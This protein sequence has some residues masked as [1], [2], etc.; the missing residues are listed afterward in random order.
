MERVGE[1]RVRVGLENDRDLALVAAGRLSHGDARHEEVD[2]LVDTG[3]VLILL[4][5]DLVERLGLVTFDKTVVSLANEDRIELD[6]AGTLTL[7]IGDRRM[8]TD[9]LV[10]P[11]GCEPLV[12]QIV[13]ESLDLIC[14]P[15]KRTLTPRPESPLRPTLK[16]KR[17]CAPPEAVL[18]L[19]PTSRA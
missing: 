11:A 12:G 19:R 14:D 1:I 3:A 6:R 15:L 10:G 18:D 5:Q 7:T 13:L 17:S 4:P 16:L 8:K 2:A 9:C